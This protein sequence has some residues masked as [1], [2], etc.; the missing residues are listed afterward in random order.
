MAITDKL[1]TIKDYFLDWHERYYNA[2]H[3][4]T[5]E[6]LEAETENRIA[7]DNDLLRR[8]TYPNFLAAQAKD[9]TR[10]QTVQTTLDN[11]NT[12]LNTNAAIGTINGL[13]YAQN[14]IRGFNPS[15][16]GTKQ[17]GLMTWKDK[18]EITALGTWYECVHRNAKTKDYQHIYNSVPCWNY[19]KKQYCVLWI[20][21]ALRI[22]YLKFSY[23]DFPKSKWDET[24]KSS[25]VYMATTK[26]FKY[27]GETKNDAI[28]W[29]HASPIYHI[30]N[31]TNHPNIM[32]GLTNDGELILRS[33]TEIT[34]AYGIYGS[35]M[36]F[37][38]DG[39]SYGR[40]H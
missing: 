33:T 11:F 13:A 2:L 26:D 10:N 38:R 7:G 12:K 16:T 37:Y 30:W 21:P 18:A 34:K 20:N 25:V 27:E 39:P 8:I 5:I 35:L 17:N 6:D 15:L 22:C 23:A 32:L 36:W 31:G 28:L 19:S 4:K 1:T 9:D 24:K 14:D 40:W 3:K 29:D